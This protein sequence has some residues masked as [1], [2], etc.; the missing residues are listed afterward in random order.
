MVYIAPQSTDAAFHFAVEE[1][2]MR[3]YPWD[4]PVMMI[5]QA[6]KFAMLG[7][8]QIAEAEVDMNTMENAGIRIVR[9]SSGGGTIFTD[10]GT[11]LYTIIMP[12][13]QE[14]TPLEILRE[15]VAKPVAEAL[16]KL[17]VPAAVEGRNDILVG[18]A[19]VS[20]LAQYVKHG[21]ICTHG[22]LLYDADL[23]LLAQLLTVNAEKIK[24]KALKSVRSRVANIRKHKDMGATPEFWSLIKNELF[25]EQRVTEYVLTEH[26]LTEIN[27]IY[28]EKYAN[29]V[30]TF[31]RAPQFT[32]HN[33]KRF[34]G[35]IVEFF[36]DVKNGAVT[37]CSIKGDFLGV[38]PVQ[39]LEELLVNKPFQRQAFAEVI[40]GAAMQNYFG[41]IT[42]EE[43]LSCVFN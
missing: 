34:T 31:G 5:W 32:Y 10:M 4:E 8:N 15:Q 2:I 6:D 36:C 24:S 23:E 18:G 40:D 25:K 41:D 30:W 22:S 29:P 12:Y 11:L 26:D 14:K 28:K 43:F 13:T 27:E 37:S 16:N 1:Y 42:K 38:L 7:S 19:K 20:G 33:S 39:G 9:R 17:D 3:H 35:G 21:R